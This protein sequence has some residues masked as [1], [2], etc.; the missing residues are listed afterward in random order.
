MTYQPRSLTRRA[1]DVACAVVVFLV[2]CGLAQ[3]PSLS[4]TGQQKISALQG[5]FGAGLDERDRFGRAIAPLGDLDGNGVNDLVISAN[6]DDDAGSNAGAVYVLFM[7]AGGTVSSKLKI[8]Q[9]IGGFTGILDGSDYFGVSLANLGDIDGDGND[10]LAVGAYKDD[11]GGTDRGAVWILFL[12]GNGV[13]KGHQKISS[14]A[15]GLV[16]PLADGE[17]FGT[18]VV[19]LGDVNGD[20]VRDLGAAGYNGG[21]AFVLFLNSNGT[22]A[23]ERRIDGTNLGG[24]TG[25]EAAFFGATLGSPG[26]LDGNGVCD[27]VVGAPQDNDGGPGR[28]SVWVLF[29]DATGSVVQIQKISA[30]SGGL[31][32]VLDDGDF[33]GVAVAGTGDLDLDGVPDLVVGAD[34][35]DDGASNAGA[36]WILSMHTDGTVKHTQ[37]VSAL[38]GGFTGTLAAGDVFGRSVA[39]VEIDGDCVPDLI[40]GAPND[41]DGG[42]DTGAAWVCFLGR[43]PWTVFGSGLAGSNGVPT[44][45]GEGTLQAGTPVSITL[46]NGLPG[47]PATFVIGATLLDLPFKGGVLCLSP[48]LLVDVT[49]DA[50]GGVVLSGTWPAG[51]D[52]GIQFY[53]QVWIGDAS[54]PQGFTASPCL[55]ATTP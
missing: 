6:K 32:D 18:G 19:G 12:D 37:K 9:G 26:D 31:P 47:A 10:D 34:G 45:D 54:G 14:T 24:V 38:E 3:A 15:G 11:D 8:T 44:L 50:L 52:C 29:L 33:F 41:E 35:D 16:G 7:N 43:A 23:A 53:F 22:V 55:A 25:L 46:G 20:G 42:I 13:V 40:V 2:P 5:G 39:C 30:T 4:V 36:V 48:D 51:I 27:L 17:F 1:T 49:V 21:A 28:G